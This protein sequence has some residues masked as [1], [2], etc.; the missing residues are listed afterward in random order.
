MAISRE[1]EADN[2]NELDLSDPGAV[3][4][5]LNRQ[6]AEFL[7]QQAEQQ[8]Q[9][10]EHLSKVE[11]EFRNKIEQLETD[12]IAREANLIEKLDA[13]TATNASNTA[14]I[15]DVSNEMETNAISAQRGLVARKR[16][17][18]TKN[19]GSGFDAN[20]IRSHFVK[21]VCTGTPNRTVN[22]GISDGNKGPSSSNDA[23]S[24]S[25]RSDIIEQ[26]VSGN[27][28]AENVRRN[29]A[30]SSSWQTVTTKTQR[31][32]IK[33]DGKIR[34]TPIQLERLD[35]DRLRAL[36]TKLTGGN[37]AKGIFI[38][39]LGDNQSPRIVCETEEAKNSVMQQP[40]RRST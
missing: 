24:S 11:Q 9:Y 35:T 1:M 32:N 10:T 23:S 33:N 15:V 8:R 12:F 5:F 13:L 14:I 37:G 2:W 25:L 38:Q 39:R 31:K 16:T 22:R 29:A 17:N 6:Q 40:E 3:R 34:V 27:S 7:L 36:G 4:E 19:S 21:R 20:D 28:S 18:D 26:N 30:T